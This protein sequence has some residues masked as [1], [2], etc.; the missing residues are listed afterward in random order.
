MF[1]TKKVWHKEC[2]KQRMFE[3]QKVWGSIVP[4]KEEEKDS[5][6]WK[7]KC[8]LSFLGMQ[9]DEWIFNV[10]S[11]RINFFY[12]KQDDVITKA[13]KRIKKNNITI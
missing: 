11:L 5:Q 13:I 10:R 2:L 9:Y 8:L 3:T 7:K 4:F 12:K 6:N 1:D